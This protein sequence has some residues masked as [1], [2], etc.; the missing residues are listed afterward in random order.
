[1]TP[2]NN[3]TWC[4]STLYVCRSGALDPILR[5]V[6]SRLYIPLMSCSRTSRDLE[7]E[8]RPCEIAQSNCASARR[9][10]VVE[11]TRLARVV[12]VIVNFFRGNSAYSVLSSPASPASPPPPLTQAH[13]KIRGITRVDS[14]T[15]VIE[16]RQSE[17]GEARGRGVEV[18][19]A[20]GREDRQC[21]QRTCV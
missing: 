6:P 18:K 21:E 11:N 10:R 9:E 17:R 15:S 19:G 8:R 14:S 4:T 12:A 20:R 7:S 5:E 16:G 2:D 1:M 3:V 13:T